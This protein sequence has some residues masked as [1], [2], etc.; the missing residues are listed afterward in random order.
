MYF[1]PWF[2]S[3]QLTRLRHCLTSSSSLS[4][5]KAAWKTSGYSWSPHAIAK[6]ICTVTATAVS[7]ACSAQ[8]HTRC[9]DVR[10]RPPN[11]TTSQPISPS[12]PPL[13]LSSLLLASLEPLESLESLES[14]PL[15]HKDHVA[16]TGVCSREIHGGT[17]NVNF[18]A[19]IQ[20]A[21]FGDAR[22]GVTSRFASD[23]VVF[24]V[25]RGNL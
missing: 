21:S 12:L 5:A 11:G 23:A 4:D 17:D 22:G 6:M 2:T 14:L 1:Q 3:R 25:G 10:H 9:L 7:L 15:L 8:T 20:A 13:S 24:M 19:S 18:V 16:I